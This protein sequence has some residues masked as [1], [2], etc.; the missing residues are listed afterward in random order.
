MHSMTGYGRGEASNGSVSVVVELKSVN[1]RFLDVQV[2]LPRA[3]SVVE[4]RFAGALKAHLSRG[5]VDVFVRRQS[6]ESGQTVVPDP[7]L[8]ERYLRAAAE[9]AKRLARTDETIPTSWVLSQPGVLHAMEQ[10]A[11]AVGEWDVI[12]TALDLAVEGLKSMRLAEGTALKADMRSHLDKIMALQAEVVEVQDGIGSR[13]EQKLHDR[14]SRLVQD[15]VDPGRLAQEVAVLADKADVSEE[16]ARILSH[17]DQFSEALESSEPVGRK[18]EFLLQE[19]NREVNTIGSKAAE[20]PV[21]AR[22]VE[23]KSVLERMREQAANVE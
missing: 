19:L 14:L 11:D 7:A 23:M 18:L 8:A 12:R 4:P 6:T 20:H 2:R 5:R 1:N 16:L 13:L 15:R 10:E 9:S 22:V 3:Y 17:C 21:S